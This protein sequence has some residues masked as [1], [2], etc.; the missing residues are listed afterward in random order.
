MKH[1]IKVTQEH[2]DKAIAQHQ[3]RGN[4]C[5]HCPIAQAAREQLNNPNL[6]VSFGVKLFVPNPQRYS[7]FKKG[8]F[9]MASEKKSFIIEIDYDTDDLQFIAEQ[10][11]LSYEQLTDEKLAEFIQEDLEEFFGCPAKVSPNLTPA[12]QE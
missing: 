3:Y 6:R 10:Q 9:F 12:S 7:L 11:G 2:I 4:V 8:V 1:V 5:D